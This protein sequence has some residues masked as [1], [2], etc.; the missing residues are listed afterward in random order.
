MFGNPALNDNT[1]DRDVDRYRPGGY[2]EEEV[3]TRSDVMTVQGTVYK[4]AILLGLAICTGVFTWGQTMSAVQTAPGAAASSGPAVMYMAVGGIGGFIAAL[5]TIFKQNWAP[6][7]APIYALL[8]GLMLGGVSA[9]Y[10]NNFGSQDVN[11]FEL[12]GIVGQAIGLTVGVTAAMLILYT[13]RIIK[14]TEK[15]RA[16]ILMAVVGAVGFNIVAYLVLPFFG[17]ATDAVTGTGPLAIGISV[18]I[19]GVAAFSLL[20]D[21]D[22]IERGAASGAPKH[23]EW[24]GA[25]A[26]MVTLV[27]L[28]LELLRLL[29]KLQSR[30]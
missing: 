15:L 6:I 27:W 11:G 5:V 24:Y 20:M 21:F 8:T 18:V 1:F 28:Y 7:T 19:C 30:D 29:S 3:D 22:L 4:T 16:G 26:L 17:V 14:V 9:M 12:Q 10:Q 23:M 25:F 2:R 13:F